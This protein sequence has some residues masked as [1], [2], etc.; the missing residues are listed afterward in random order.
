MEALLLEV[1]VQSSRMPKILRRLWPPWR[2][3]RHVFSFKRSIRQSL[4]LPRGPGD[5]FLCLHVG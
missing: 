3:A 2:Q 1:K 5:D 4:P